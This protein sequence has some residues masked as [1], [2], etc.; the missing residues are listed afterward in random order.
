[1]ADPI[2]ARSSIPVPVYQQVKGSLDPLPPESKEMQARIETNQGD[3]KVET[4]DDKF[5]DYLDQASITNLEANQ[6]GTEYSVADD[7]QNKSVYK[8]PGETSPI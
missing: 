2:Q 1:M 5:K 8:T 7:I 3:K 4:Q 6:Q